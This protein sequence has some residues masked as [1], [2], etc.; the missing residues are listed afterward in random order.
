MAMKITSINK[1]ADSAGLHNDRNFD[2]S[3]AEHIDADRLSLNKY[4]THNGDTRPFIEVEKD[5][6]DLHFGDYLKKRA[7]INK[8]NGHKK[9]TKT[10][11][12]YYKGERTRPE[13]KIL[14]VG[15]VDEHP[16]GD[17]LWE[18]AL[19]YKDKFE[20]IYGDSC[21]I[22]DMALHMDEATPHVHIRRVWIAEDDDGLEYVSEN[23]AL[24][25]LGMTGIGEGRISRYNNPKVEFTIADT[26]L[27]KEICIEHGLDIDMTAAVNKQKHY[28]IAKYQAKKDYERTERQLAPLKK[29]LEEME[30]E[31]SMLDNLI[32]QMENFL[33]SPYFED[34]YT[35]EIEELKKKAKKQR[36]EAIIKIYQEEAEAVSKDGSFGE[37]KS[38]LKA[39]K[40]LLRA[41]RFI[42]RNGLKAAYDRH[43]GND[44]QNQKMEKFI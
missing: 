41:E 33:T 12:Q 19:A 18:C 15:N 27:F 40:A 20:D 37:H 23:K 17:T 11:N 4:Y 5:F 26:E 25:K 30:E 13:D 28:E 2:L 9:R 1:R 3:L 10:L 7:D 8:K 16:D 32:P 34:E 29:E 42:E 38:A 44:A 6:Y 36:Y 22:L 21:K 39:R 24:E 43:V 14:Q 31:L 35:Q